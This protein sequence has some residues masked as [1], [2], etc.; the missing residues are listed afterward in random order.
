[1]F[2]FS[3]TFGDTFSGFIDHMLLNQ[4]IKSA[5][6]ITPFTANP[7]L[8]RKIIVGCYISE[9]HDSIE[10]IRIEYCE[11]QISILCSLLFKPIHSSMHYRIAPEIY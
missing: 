7:G 3:P 2:I 5:Q 6:L 9:K 8:D 10:E 11:Q 4:V 1:L